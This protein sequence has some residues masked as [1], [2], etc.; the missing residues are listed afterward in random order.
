MPS[1]LFFWTSDREEKMRENGVEIEDFEEIVQNPAYVSKSRTSQRF[2]Q[3][4]S[5]G[6]DY[7]KQIA[8]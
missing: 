8:T 5:H 7:L 6:F 1:Y 2:V 3:E 4:S